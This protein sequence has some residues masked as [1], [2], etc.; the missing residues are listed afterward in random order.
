MLH[1]THFNPS[2]FLDILCSHGIRRGPANDRVQRA[3]NPQKPGLEAIV[4]LDQPLKPADWKAH[5][6]NL[7]IP[8]TEFERWHEHYRPPRESAI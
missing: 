6:Q 2:N 1:T 4:R 8:E 7:D 3:I 5:L